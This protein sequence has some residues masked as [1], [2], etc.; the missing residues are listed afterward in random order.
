MSWCKG[1][2]HDPTA[3]APHFGRA[4]DGVLS[5]VAALHN[6]VGSQ[7]L[8][9]IQRSILGKNYDEGATLECSEHVTSLRVTANRAR[10][11]FESSHRFVAVDADNQCIGGL[12]GCRQ[13]V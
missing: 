2:N 5:I 9:Q 8:D 11:P 12:A 13:N 6:Y 10:W 1:H 4:D 3:P 7:K